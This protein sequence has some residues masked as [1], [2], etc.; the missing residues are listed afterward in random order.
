[1]NELFATA[2]AAGRQSVEF[3]LKHQQP[4][5]GYIW[6]GFVRDAYHKQPYA[7]G[8]AGYEGPAHRL[9]TWV[10]E[11]TLQA[12]GG[13]KDYNG[14]VYKH[15]WLFL[16][17]HRLGRLDVSYPVMAFLRSCQAPCGGFPHFRGGPEI[18]SLA[19]GWMGISALA[20]GQIDLAEAIAECCLSM[21]DQQPDPGR[22]YYQMSLEGSLVTADTRPDA[23]FVD[24]GKP[25]QCYWE[26]GLP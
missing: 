18:R 4:D 10:R 22:F 19:T 24:L 9:L 25:E 5:G 14:D 21:L 17:A 20:F 6:E 7:W 16:G 11:N 26:I 15:S 3:Q 23:P 2:R 12:E 8:I 13:L 1:M